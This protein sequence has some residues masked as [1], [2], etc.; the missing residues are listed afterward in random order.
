MTESRLYYYRAYGWDILTSGRMPPPS[1]HWVS[2]RPAVVAAH[3][4][5]RFNGEGTS[6]IAVYAYTLPR[7][8]QQLAGDTVA[9][10]CWVSNGVDG[11]EFLPWA[12][13]YRRVVMLYGMGVHRV[14]YSIGAHR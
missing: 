1:R 12:D 13:A 3:R 10:G 4:T 6:M 5:M 7:F 8:R 11:V 14:L 9:V 2:L